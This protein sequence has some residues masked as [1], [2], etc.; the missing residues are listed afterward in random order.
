[1]QVVESIASVWAYHLR[2]DDAEETLCGRTDVFADGLPIEHW[3]HRSEHI[4]EK[5]CS[6]CEEAYR[7]LVQNSAPARPEE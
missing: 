4:R 7:Q 2:L 3:G 6:K 5:Y 1:M